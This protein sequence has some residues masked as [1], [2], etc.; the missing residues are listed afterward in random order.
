MGAVGSVQFG[1][2]VLNVHLDGSA[3]GAEL[4]GDLF[5]GQSFSDIAQD[6][7]LARSQRDLRKI[8]TEALCN[9]RGHHSLT[10]VH[11]TYGTEHFGV[12]HFLQQI[13]TDAGFDSAVY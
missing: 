7:D 2:D 3:R 11:S 6:F 1:E 10:S 13:P 5:V 12:Y 8:S 4:M 9:F